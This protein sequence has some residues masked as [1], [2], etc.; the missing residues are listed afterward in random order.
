[1]PEKQ[2]GFTK[3]TRKSSRNGR[4]RA[5]A[6]LKGKRLLTVVFG[7]AL[8]IGGVSEAFNGAQYLV[9]KDLDSLQVVRSTANGREVVADVKGAFA[10]NSIYKIARAVPDRFLGQQQSLFDASWLTSPEIEEQLAGKS[11]LRVITDKIRGEFFET[12]PFGNLI[13]MKSEKY[14]V[15][16]A[17]VA[18]VIETESQFRW[19]AKSPVGARG[20]MQLMPR[21]GR[22]MGARDLYDPNQNI[23]AGVKYISYL[24]KRFDGNLKK[25]IAAYNA[26]EGNVRR[27]G[28]IPPFRETRSYVKKVMIRY[29]KRNREL[30]QFQRNAD[31][32]A[33]RRDFDRESDAR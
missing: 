19:R 22:W 1:M 15:D 30:K 6:V 11:E 14:G 16:P 26:G 2:S 17:L 27:Y 9:E 24:D 21:T 12:L 29:E 31:E 4:H 13:H 23:D 7:A 33:E 5:G 32:V 10:S 8:S 3:G 18:A 20:L 25:T 28:G